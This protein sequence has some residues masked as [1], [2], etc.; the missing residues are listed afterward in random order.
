MVLV[1][2]LVLVLAEFLPL[3]SPGHPFHSDLEP[4]SRSLGRSLRG[5]VSR[6]KSR[7][8]GRSLRDR[9]SRPLPGLYARAVSR[10]LA[11]A[12]CRDPKLSFR[13]FEWVLW[14]CLCFKEF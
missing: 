10:S 9:V 2:V 3:D 12:E 14:R 5:R 1:L 4:K 13:S 7:S 11:A 8:L 6:P